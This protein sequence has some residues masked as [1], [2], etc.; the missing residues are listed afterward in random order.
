MLSARAHL[1]LLR[2]ADEVVEALLNGHVGVH[3]FRMPSSQYPCNLVKSTC[4][5]LHHVVRASALVSQHVLHVVCEGEAGLLSEAVAMLRIG[6][7]LYLL[8][9]SPHEGFEV[10]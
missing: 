8:C 7:G 2:P 9:S 5:E 3:M 1:L 10:G 4:L 6:E